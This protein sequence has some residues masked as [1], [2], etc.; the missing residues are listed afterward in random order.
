[1]IRTS[2]ILLLAIAALLTVGLA[3][4]DYSVPMPQVVGALMSD[5][6]TPPDV[7]MIVMQLRMPRL[8]LALLVGL[9][10]GTAGAI[11]QAVMRNPLAE[12]GLLGINSGAALAAMVLMVGMER[13]P[14]YLLPAASFAGATG[15][16]LAI[17]VLSW[18]HG[19]SSLRIILIG[20]GLAA[21]GNAATSFLTAF[22]DV[23]LV[24]RAMLWLAGSVADANWSR[25][26]SMFT[27]SLLPLLLVWM[28]ARELDTISL[29]DDNARSLGQ[30][31][32]LVR[33]LMILMCTLLSGAAVAFA[34][35]I[36]FVGLIAPH[37][38]RRLVGHGHV[39]VIPAAALLGAVLVMSADLVGRTI[40]A[41]AQLPAGLLTALLG[42]PFF[43]WLMW[44]RRHV[45]A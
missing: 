32:N 5:P 3:S 39:R 8:L 19:T 44:E 30:R 6:D 21:L 27:W 23:R 34:G 40:I 4:G 35:L 12:P 9:A 25:V 37:M 22:G 10:L 11:A 28:A 1:M 24:Q 42:A 7:A 14:D 17:Y 20:I 38:A 45:A 2:L 13:A 16:A 18:R 29:G 26:Q 41:P 31:V 43:A 33:G 36:G 15:M